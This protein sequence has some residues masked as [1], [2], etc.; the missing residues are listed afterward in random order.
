MRHRRRRERGGGSR[1]RSRH[2]RQRKEDGAAGAPP[3]TNAPPPGDLYN[4]TGGHQLHP[5]PHLPPHDWRGPAGDPDGRPPPTWRGPPQAWRPV[6]ASHYPPPRG[7]PQWYSDR[8]PPRPM[9]YPPPGPGPRPV[10]SHMSLAPPPPDYGWPPMGMPPRPEEAVRYRA[11]PP[12]EWRGPSDMQRAA[13]P[14]PPYGAQGAPSYWG[15]PMPPGTHWPG[16]PPGY[17]PPAPPGDHGRN[18]DKDK[19]SKTLAPGGE[20]PAAACG[21]AVNGAAAPPGSFVVGRPPEA[22]D[23]AVHA[24]AGAEEEEEEDVTA[25][26]FSSV[27][28]LKKLRIVTSCLSETMLARLREAGIP[29]EERGTRQAASLSCDATVVATDTSSSAAEV[30]CARLGLESNGNAQRARLPS[31]MPTPP[32]LPLCTLELSHSGLWERFR[33]HCGT[34]LPPEAAAAKCELRSSAGGGNVLAPLVASLATPA[35]DVG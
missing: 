26:T 28:Q 10:H 19:G 14:P 6:G 7:D 23:A 4:G 2:R 25:D 9:S 3:P 18:G 24:A 15:P 33:Q 8:P 35:G 12:A 30:L 5:A 17:Q 13:V 1:S 31:T 27:E 20:A 21:G 32:R 34:P 16:A 29:A 22:G 11:E